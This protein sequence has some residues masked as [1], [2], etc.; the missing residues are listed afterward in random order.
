MDGPDA[1][2]FQLRQRPLEIAG[3]RR[4]RLGR[5]ALAFDL[6]PETQLE[7][8]GGEL[9]ERDGDDVIELG[10]ACG[11]RRHHAADERRRLARA[12]RGLDH[13]RAVEIRRDAIALGLI[14]EPN[15]GHGI[16]RRRV[17]ALR[18]SRGLRF[19]RASS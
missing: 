9:R 13:E 16:P 4:S 19:T 2:L 10:T 7:L 11:E 5:Q 6:A 3:R 14:G 15:V 17:S 18:R 1:R 12:C 8:A